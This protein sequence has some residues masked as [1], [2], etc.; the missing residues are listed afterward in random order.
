MIK[1]P[2]NKLSLKIVYAKKLE[3]TKCTDTSGNL[4]EFDLQFFTMKKSL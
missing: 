3:L 2:K 1:I 4:R